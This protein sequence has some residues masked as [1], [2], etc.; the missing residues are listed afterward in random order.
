MKLTSKVISEAVKAKECG[1]SQRQIGKI[2]GLSKGEVYRILQVI[3]KENVTSVMIEQMSSEEVINLFL[4]RHAVPVRKKDLPDFK[5]IHSCLSMYKHESLIHRW[6]VYRRKNPDGYGYTR[7]TELYRLWCGDHCVKPVLITNETPG[8]FIYIDWAG[9]T[10]QTVFT[11]DEKPSTIYFFVTTLGISQMPY[12]EAF[13][14]MKTPNYILGHINAMKWYGGVPKYCKPDNCKTA[15]I[16]NRDKDFVMNEVYEDLQNYYGYI[17]LPA[18]PSSPSDKNDVESA[19]GICER[20]IIT[21]LRDREFGS[22]EEMNAEIRR[23]TMAKAK[24]LFHNKDGS[25][26]E[27]FIEM[28]KPLLKPLPPRDF[29]IFEYQHVIVG[30]DY[31]VHIQG[32]RHKYS[33]PYQY[34]GKN[35]VLKYSLTTLIILNIEGSLIAEHERHYDRAVLI[36]TID[37]HRPPNHQIAVELRIKDSESYLEYAR[38]IGPNTT[39]VIRRILQSKPYPEQTYRACMGVV[40]FVWNKEC[41]KAQME[42][43]CAEAL[44]IGAVSYSA[45]KNIL[46]N[47]RYRQLQQPQ[48]SLPQHKNIRGKENYK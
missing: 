13:T 12:V 18:R 2:C 37:S 3:A 35:V 43:I 20:W 21:E 36:H 28:D 34:I 22:L 38:M 27:W 41:T 31:H 5:E 10:L 23:L 9:D 48:E 45:I 39:E 4:P 8:E 24:E 30:K 32:D 6:T 11:G 46:K 25:R 33:V 17:V 1:S 42:D 19:V 47:R 40:A 26:W 29:A 15:I 14:D 44:E 7:F 16:T